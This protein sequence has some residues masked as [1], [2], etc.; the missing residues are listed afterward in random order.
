MGITDSTEL[1]FWSFSASGVTD[2]GAHLDLV[3]VQGRL[4]E[5]GSRMNKTV[6]DLF[7]PLKKKKVSKLK[8]PVKTGL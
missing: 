2:Q 3:V 7:L 8:R 5:E 6:F 4:L 1:Q